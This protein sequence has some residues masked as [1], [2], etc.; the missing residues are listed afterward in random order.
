[1]IDE[2]AIRKAEL[3]RSVTPQAQLTQPEQK[4]QRFW[5][6]NTIMILLF[7]S[8]IFSMSFVKSDPYR[9]VSLGI[10][11]F[12]FGILIKHYFKRIEKIVTY[13][14]VYM[15][16]CIYWIYSRIL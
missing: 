14:Y 1:M 15:A 13:K 4:K 11:L 3:K 2:A 5:R 10:S 7:A 8:M 12:G 16:V 9:A 6:W